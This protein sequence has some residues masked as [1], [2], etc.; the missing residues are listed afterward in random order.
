MSTINEL[1]KLELMESPY[2]QPLIGMIKEIEAQIQNR[3]GT[4]DA[5]KRKKKKKRDQSENGSAAGRSAVGSSRRFNLT[6]NLA[7]GLQS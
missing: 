1:R 5:T 2:S 6:R 3:F 7:S 4:G